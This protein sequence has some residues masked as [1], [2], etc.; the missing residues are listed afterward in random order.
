MQQMGLYNAEISAGSLMPLPTPVPGL[1]I[2][3]SFLWS[4]EAKIGLEDGG[5]DRPCAVLLTTITKDGQQIVTVLPVTHT[6]PADEQER[7]NWLPTPAG[8]YF[9]CLR[10]YMPEDSMLDGRYVLPAPMRR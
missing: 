5:K 1:V 3:Y 10:A 9:L 4:H 6:P 8:A 7:A 2:R